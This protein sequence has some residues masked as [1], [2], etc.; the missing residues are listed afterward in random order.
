MAT[1]TL[2]DMEILRI[3]CGTCRARGPACEGCMMTAL[4]GP[5]GE[6]VEFDAEEQRALRAMTDSGLLPPLRLVRPVRA[7]SP[8]PNPDLATG[9]AIR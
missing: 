9:F 7:V 8:P 2:S 3:D 6:V 4:M 1:G 5:V